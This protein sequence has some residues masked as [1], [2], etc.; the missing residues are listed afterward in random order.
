M[1]LLKGNHRNA[2]F[3]SE[4]REMGNG[5]NDYARGCKVWDTAANH[6][7]YADDSLIFCWYIT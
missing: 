1:R 4:E 6:V 2:G 7:T 3:H 5:L